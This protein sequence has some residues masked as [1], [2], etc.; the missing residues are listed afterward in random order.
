MRRFP[1]LLAAFLASSGCSFTHALVTGKEIVNY[2]VGAGIAVDSELESAGFQVVGKAYTDNGEQKKTC[3]GNYYDPCHLFSSELSYR[4]FFLPLGGRESLTLPSEF[5]VTEGIGIY[6]QDATASIELL[7]GFLRMGISSR[8]DS[9]W[10]PGIGIS[11]EIPMFPL[12]FPLRADAPLAL[13]VG[14]FLSLGIDKDEVKGPV[15]QA[16]VGVIY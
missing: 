6:P 16:H 7:L 1:Y 11:A 9:Y 15:F 12:A 4:L 2:R 10:T 5:G 13:Q 14:G 8:G 3:Q